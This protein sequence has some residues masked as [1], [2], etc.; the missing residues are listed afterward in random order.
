MDLISKRI[1]LDRTAA[2]VVLAHLPVVLA[3]GAAHRGVG[4][5]MTPA[6]H[7]FILLVIVIGPL[8]GLWRIRAGSR[9]AGHALV[10]LSMAGA[11]VFGATHHFVLDGADHVARVPANAWGAVFQTT[12]VILAATEALGTA[13]GACGLAWIAVA[14]SREGRAP[15]A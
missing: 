15:V 9:A 5:A 7:V 2:V 12:A 6:A 8:A 13:V 10:A 11:L 3:H 1:R 14:R 4:V